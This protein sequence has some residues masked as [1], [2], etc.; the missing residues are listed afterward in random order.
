MN[1]WILFD[2][3]RT[4]TEHSNVHSTNKTDEKE[5]TVN[6]DYDSETNLLMK[7]DLLN[8][9]K[10]PETELENDVDN[11]PKVDLFLPTPSMQGRTTCPPTVTILSALVF[12]IWSHSHSLFCQTTD[13]S[14]PVLPDWH[15]LSSLSFPSSLFSLSLFFPSSSLILPPSFS[16]FP[17]SF[18]S[19]FF[20]PFSHFSSSLFSPVFFLFSVLFGDVN[21][22][23][24]HLRSIAVICH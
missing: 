19:L 14:L 1:C 16:F 17:L 4:L 24:I 21:S 9:S 2:I 22:W 15:S 13:L 11:N 18:L 10:G 23:M 6:N 20:F 12:S 7:I 5:D 8:E 3:S